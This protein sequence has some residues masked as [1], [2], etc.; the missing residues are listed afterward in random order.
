MHFKQPLTVSGINTVMYYSAT[1]IEMS[2][3]GNASSAIWWAAVAATVNFTFTF[4]GLYYVDK[5][6]ACKDCCIL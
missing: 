4:V 1:V 6:G 3:V 5:K 2:G